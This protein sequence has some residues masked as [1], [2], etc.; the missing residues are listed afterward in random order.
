MDEQPGFLVPERIAT[1]VLEEPPFAGAEIEVSI[2]LN[3][4]TLQ[5]IRRW[6]ATDINTLASDGSE[7]LLA[8]AAEVFASKLRGWNLRD[9]DGPIPATKEGILSL[10]MDLM[11][12]IISTWTGAIG[13]P[14][15]LPSRPARRPSIGSSSSA[16]SRRTSST[17]RTRTGSSGSSR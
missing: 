14:H 11:S 5:A 9:A 13:S 2:S 15:P 6:L 17:A 12:R 4:V 7:I 3:M 16:G 10:P 1:L 8:E